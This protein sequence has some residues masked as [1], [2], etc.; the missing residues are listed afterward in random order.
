MTRDRILGAAALVASLLAAPAVAQEIS[1]ADAPV[2]ALPKDFVSALTGQGRPGRWEIVEDRTATGGKALAQLDS[3]RTDYRFPLAILELPLPADVEVTVRF[4][5]V[6]GRVDQAGGV[7]VRLTDRNNY[8]LARANALENNVT[9]YRVVAGK[10][11]QIAG[12]KTK[13]TLGAWHDLTLRAE[14][15]AFTVLFDGRQALTARDERFGAPGKVALWTKA[16]S[17]TRFDRLEIKPLE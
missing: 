7:A 13:V 15:N 4:M 3:D 14:G 16:D 12:A 11:Q 2:G 9:F 6:S 10:R 5:P 17:I 1:F 8:Y